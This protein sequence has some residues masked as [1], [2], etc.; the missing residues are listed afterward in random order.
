MDYETFISEN[1]QEVTKD[2]SDTIKSFKSKGLKI[3]F[4]YIAK[5]LKQIDLLE[6]TNERQ[7][8]IQSFIF[9]RLLAN[10]DEINDS[11]ENN[12]NTIENDFLKRELFESSILESILDKNH[13]KSDEH[14]EYLLYVESN[15]EYLYTQLEKYLNN[16]MK[17]IILI[18]DSYLNKLKNWCFESFQ[19]PK[20][21]TRKYIYLH[22][23]NNKVTINKLINPSNHKR[24]ILDLDKLRQAV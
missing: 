16:L 15:Q 18:D 24:N 5:K 4:D 9:E 12:I 19:T 1:I 2:L 21:Y 11:I 6:F 13:K 20:F 7:F 22:L 14:Q 3:S 8:F 10:L 23:L 17:N